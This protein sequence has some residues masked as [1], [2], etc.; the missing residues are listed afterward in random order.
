MSYNPFYY[1]FDN[2]GGDCTN[3]ASQCLYS[4]SKV[5]NYTKNLGW[6]YN[7]SFDR[8]ASWTSVEYFYKFLIQNANTFDSRSDFE[9]PF[10]K[11]VD[12]IDTQIGDFVQLGDKNGKFFHTLIIVG[13]LRDK[14]PLVASHSL[15]SYNK[16]LNFYVY[17]KVRY[18]HILG[19]KKL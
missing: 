4:G 14:T 18:I 19:V 16:P 5:M 1:N 7:S 17:Q 3:F 10:G 2:I 15:P 12:L 13:Y 9:G 8:S 6:Y 11:S